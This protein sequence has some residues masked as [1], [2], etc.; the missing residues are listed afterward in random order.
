MTKALPTCWERRIKNMGFWQNLYESY[1]KVGNEV[2]PLYHMTLKTRIEVVLDGEG[3]LLGISKLNNEETITIPCTEESQSHRSGT[4]PASHPLFDQVKHLQKLSY[5]D[6]LSKWCDKNVKVKAIY[7]Y[8]S[9]QTLIADLDKYLPPKVS[10][11]QYND[12][13]GVR[14]KVQIHD[15]EEDKVWADIEV[16]Q[17]WQDY[18]LST[19]GDEKCLD[20]IT[21]GEA[22]YAAKHPKVKGNAKLIS[23]KDGNIKFTYRTDRFAD[24][25]QAFSIG[26]ESSQKAHQFLRYL[27]DDRGYYC[28]EQVILSYTIGQTERL[29]PPLDDTKSILDD[30][31]ATSNVDDSDDG[32]SLRAETGHDYSESLKKALA[33][34]KYGNALQKHERTAVIALDAT[35]TTTGRLSI[36]F[37]RELGRSE[38][39]D[40]IADWHEDCKWHQIFW[41]EDKQPRKY[42]GAPSVDKIIEAVYGK[43][44]GGN[45]KSYNKIK[46]AARERLLHCIFDGKPISED[47]VKAAVRRCSNPLGLA[48]K[49]KDIRNVFEQILSTTCALV[50]KDYKQREEEYKLA[51]ELDRDDRDY[52]YGRLLGAADKLE[53]YVNR[54]NGNKRITSAIRNMNAF[55]QR[56]YA[57]WLTIEADLN[58]YIKF[59][60]GQS[61]VALEE[62]DEIKNQFD[63]NSVFEDDSPLKGIYLLSYSCE[64]IRINNLVVER[65]KKKQLTKKENKL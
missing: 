62:L 3:K 2:A 1:E 59:L 38:Y 65:R 19:L 52:L 54:K 18:Y 50:R 22:I 21:G 7:I 25:K 43:P 11:K 31:P 58:S 42:I 12:K 17:V 45:D 14:F 33:S 37:Y 15:V 49:D 57:T 56:P 6:A 44:R 63:P 35:T 28:D 46:K 60:R 51:I 61:I 13:D 53:E 26:Y 47:Y 23:S 34:L 32:V 39:L 9:S 29:P 64:R 20:F 48:E 4:N 5:L 16:R 30:Y 36:T 10:K 40:K 8:L 24:A 41:D 55:S 27:I